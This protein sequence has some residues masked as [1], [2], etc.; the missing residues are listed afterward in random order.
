MEDAGSLCWEEEGVDAVDCS[1]LSSTALQRESDVGDKR[2][3]NSRLETTTSAS[4][5]Q[6][7]SLSV[8]FSETWRVPVLYFSAFKYDCE[9]DDLRGGGPASDAA[10]ISTGALPFDAVAPLLF[11]NGERSDEAG[12]VSG[13]SCGMGDASGNGVW[14]SVTVE[15][16]PATGAP[17]FMLHPCH[18]ADWMAALLAT[19]PPQPLQPPPPEGGGKREAQE[20]LAQELALLP[21]PA[22]NY[23][24]AW[25]SVVGPSVGLDVPA[26]FFFRQ[27]QF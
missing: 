15:A 19:S 4:M 17:C 3:T 25:L 2:E 23:L 9:T 10:E 1:T 16:H 22:T 12:G 11:G 26:E 13:S 6:A 8:A 24:L 14:P 18:T 27:G 5:T 7:W 20:Q 21:P